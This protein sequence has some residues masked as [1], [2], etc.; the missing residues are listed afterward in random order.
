LRERLWSRRRSE[1]EAD[2]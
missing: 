1:V 2:Y